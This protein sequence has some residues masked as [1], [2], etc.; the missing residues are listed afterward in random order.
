MIQ[1]NSPYKVIDQRKYNTW[2][3]YKHRIDT[4]GCGCQHDCSYCYAKSLLDFRNHWDS[5]KPKKANLSQIKY[6][7]SEVPKNTVIRLGS[8]TDCFQPIELKER[9]TYETI[10]L[11][12]R[13]N[14]NYL[15]VTKSSTVSNDEYIK[16]YDKNLAH[17]QVTITNTNN[18]EALRYEKASTITDR[19]KSI[20]KLYHNGFDVSVRLSPF[21]DGFIDYDILNSIRCDKILVEFLKVNHFIMKWFDI[22]YSDF[23]V[24]YGGYRHLPLFKKV[25]LLKNIT[26][27]KQLSVGEYVKEHHEYFS[28]FVNYNKNDCCNLDIN[29]KPYQ[30]IIQLDLFK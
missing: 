5:K 10:K 15:I 8:L 22:D 23:M 27:F 3:V 11:L 17:F 13:F 7:L 14:I 18:K 9:I 6:I 4:Y 24:K 20:E 1:Y 16:I 12:N 21:I 30:K 29:F 28:K 2:C 19:I 25:V 26:G